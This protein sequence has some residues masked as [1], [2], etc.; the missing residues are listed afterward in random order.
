[1]G[2]SGVAGAG[3]GGHGGILEDMDATLPSPRRVREILLR[4]VARMEVVKQA[5]ADPSTLEHGVAHRAAA[6]MKLIAAGIEGI[7]PE[8]AASIGEMGHQ[9]A[10]ILIMMRH[11][12]VR[13]GRCV[14][15]LY[16]I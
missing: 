5:L 10:D 2:A 13:E 16:G 4:E 12:E 14:H 15:G 1:M 6:R 7:S 9:V 11:E 3:G 8:T